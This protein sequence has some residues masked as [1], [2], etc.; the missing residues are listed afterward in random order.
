[1]SAPDTEQFAEGELRH[2]DDLARDVAWLW[3]DRG[4]GEVEVPGRVHA[5]LDR[6]ADAYLPEDP[7]DAPQ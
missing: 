3:R 5:A 7:Q 6:L 4:A 1:M 2:R